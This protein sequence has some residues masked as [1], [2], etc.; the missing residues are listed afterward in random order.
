MSLLCPITSS[1]S[2]SHAEQNPTALPQP[3]RSCR[4]DP[5]YTSVLDISH[6]APCCSLSS[7]LLASLWTWH[8]LWPQGLC[9]C[10]SSAWNALPSEICVALSF[11]SFR[12]SPGGYL[13]SE[14]FPDHLSKN[15][16]LSPPYHSSCFV[17]LYFL[18]VC[19]L[20]HCFHCPSI[21]WFYSIANYRNNPIREKHWKLLC[22]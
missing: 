1:G 8:M 11:T 9:T 6:H 14:A 18:F 16:T 2:L 12:A 17:F 5:R 22:S 21:I 15:S 13:F 20:E 19:L 7:S 10:S 4:F 3:T